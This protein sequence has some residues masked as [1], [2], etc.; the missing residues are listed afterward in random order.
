MRW[1]LAHRGYINNCRLHI[2]G[3]RR[4]FA[5]SLLIAMRSITF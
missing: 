1:Q 3:M 2:P 4:R 5:K